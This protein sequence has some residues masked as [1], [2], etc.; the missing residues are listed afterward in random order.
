MFKIKTISMVVYV[1]TNRVVI[2]K[3]INRC[4]VAKNI[5]S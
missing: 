2:S 1:V 3:T 5:D 4:V